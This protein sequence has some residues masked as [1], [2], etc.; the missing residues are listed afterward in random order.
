MAKNP[1]SPTPAQIRK[2]RAHSGLSQTAAAKVVF[3]T[4][5][6][7]QNWEAGKHQMN[8]IYWHCFQSHV[9]VMDLQRK[10]KAK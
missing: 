10:G 1:D 5:R 8:P 2:L 3:S 4:L 9:M 6:S 7:W